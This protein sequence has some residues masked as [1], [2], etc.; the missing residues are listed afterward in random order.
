MLEVLGW[1][2]SH[3]LPNAVAVVSALQITARAG[4]GRKPVSSVIRP[5]S[6]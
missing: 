2:D 6:Q 5:L 3:R 4:D 1:F